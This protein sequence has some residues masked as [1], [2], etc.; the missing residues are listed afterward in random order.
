[1]STTSLTPKPVI[2]HEEQ[3]A[4]FIAR[5]ELDVRMV[6]ALAGDRTLNA[7][8][9]DILEKLFAER[10]EGLY[11]D[12]LYSLTHRAFPSRQAKHLWEEITLH[13]KSLKVKLNRDVG[14]AVAAHD[15]LANVAGLMQGVTIIEETKMATLANVA[16]R[17]GLTG[18]YDQTSFKHK[19]KEEIERQLRYGGVLSL[20]MFDIDHFK[21][22]NDTYGHAEGD[23]VLRNV[24]DILRKQVRKIDTAARYGGEEFAVI[25]PEVDDKAGFIFAERLRQKVQDS[26]GEA[27]YKITIS[28]GVFTNPN[29]QAI[30]AEEFIK[31]TDALLYEAKRGG[32]N[33]VCQP[34]VK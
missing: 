19:L 4:D 14:I 17:D 28:L 9:Q 21:G 13:R 8:E 11:A 15:Y 22:I 5:G 33:R 7:R 1:M 26:F 25:L 24:S 6:S 16:T 23:S 34:Q 3:V 18:L 27:P 20:V 10:G 29:G 12:M 31:R 30:T 32:R 2:R